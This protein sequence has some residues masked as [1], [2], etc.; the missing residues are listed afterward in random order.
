MKKLIITILAIAT[1]AL[2]ANK[3][4]CKQTDDY[5]WKVMFTCVH[6]TYAVKEIYIGLWKNGSSFSVDKFMKD[7]SRV[8]SSVYFNMYDHKTHVIESTYD[9]L[10][11]LVHKD[12][13][14]LDGNQFSI[15][16]YKLRNQY[17]LRRKK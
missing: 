9:D 7:G 1:M 14:K 6:P 12:D 16:Y 8:S 11:I 3:P 10:G 2:A 4:V 17:D 15:L 5:G 13:L